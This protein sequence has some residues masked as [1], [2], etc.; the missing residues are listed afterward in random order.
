MT[1]RAYS[2]AQLTIISQTLLRSTPKP[3]GKR[4][5]TIFIIP[6]ILYHW[7]HWVGGSCPMQ[8]LDCSFFFLAHSLAP[9]LF[10]YF[11]IDWD[12]RHKATVLESE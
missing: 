2:L 3:P 6:V 4:E 12:A 9:H 8:Q 1:A 11:W 10:L 7:E 5:N